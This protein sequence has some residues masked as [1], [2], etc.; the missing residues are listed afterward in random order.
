MAQVIE[1]PASDLRPFDM[2]D[3]CTLVV[4]ITVDTNRVEVW[5]A[6][7]VEFHLSQRCDPVDPEHQPLGPPPEVA[8]RVMKTDESI[9][10]CR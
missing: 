8:R 9:R 10:V 4:A 6:P 1:L 3:E 7:A 5:T 2:I